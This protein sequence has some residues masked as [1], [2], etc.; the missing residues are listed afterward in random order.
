MSPRFHE[1]IPSAVEII[2]RPLRPAYAKLRERVGRVIFGSGADLRTEG[3]VKLEELGLAGPERSYYQPSR[4]STLPR[5]LPRREV[6]DQDVFIDYGAGM[7]RVVCQAAV[8]YPFKRVIGVELASELNGDRP[9]EYR[10]QQAP[11]AV[12]P[13]GVDHGG[14]A[15]VHSPL[16]HHGGLLL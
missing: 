16:R 8:G 10:A 5:V 1:E 12:P 2:L 15:R 4:W 14:R 11:P 7:G 13:G 6:S 9:H 3:T